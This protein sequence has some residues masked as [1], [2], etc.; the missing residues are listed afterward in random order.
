MET[1]HLREFWRG[2][3]GLVVAECVISFP[4]ESQIHIM[5]CERSEGGAEKHPA[6]KDYV[7]VKD[8]VVIIQDKA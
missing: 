3:L 7:R 8:S 4:N 6:I 1:V 5:E 2:G